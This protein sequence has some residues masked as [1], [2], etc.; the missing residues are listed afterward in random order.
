M[1]IRPVELPK[2]LPRRLQQV[3]NAYSVTVSGLPGNVQATVKAPIQVVLLSPAPDTS[4]ESALLVKRRALG[5]RVRLCFDLHLRPPCDLSRSEA[6]H[7]RFSAPASGS[8]DLGVSIWAPEVVLLVND[9]RVCKRWWQPWLRRS[10]SLTFIPRFTYGSFTR[11]HRSAQDDRGHP[12][13][14]DPAGIRL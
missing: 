6:W 11:Q 12:G 1:R 5:E 10:G 8:T 3:G 9:S 14:I 4:A 2:R 7:V 13:I